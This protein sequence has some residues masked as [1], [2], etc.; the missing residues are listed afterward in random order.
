MDWAPMRCTLQVDTR[1][2]H[3]N[4]V[5]FDATSQNQAR[6]LP[7]MVSGD[8]GPYPHPPSMYCIRSSYVAHGKSILL[9]VPVHVDNLYNI[10][11]KICYRYMFVEQKQLTASFLCAH[12]MDT[13]LTVESFPR[14]E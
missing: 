6:N 8:D 11:I 13:Y 7:S 5:R 3:I 10:R 4:N 14:K 2:R 9:E 1:P 12:L